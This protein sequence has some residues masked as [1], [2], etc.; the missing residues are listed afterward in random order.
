[1]EVFPVSDDLQSPRHHS[2]DAVGFL[3]TDGQLK[4]HERRTLYAVRD[5]FS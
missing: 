4:N 3:A 2:S 5:E 1:M